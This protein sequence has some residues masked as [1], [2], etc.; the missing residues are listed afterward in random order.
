MGGQAM[1][2]YALPGQSLA[3]EKLAQQEAELARLRAEGGQ[4]AIPTQNAVTQAAISRPVEL[5][6][7]IA[8]APVAPQAPQAPSLA[9]G[10]MAESAATEKLGQEEASIYE[11]TQKQIAKEEAEQA[12]KVNA[13]QQEAD[14]LRQ[15]IANT[16]IEP[17]GFWEKRSTGEKI[18]AGIG[19]FLSSLTPQGAQN[20]IKIIDDEI[21]RDISLQEK[22]LAN[23]KNTL[24]SLEQKLGSLDAAK[25]AIRLKAAQQAELELKKV[26]AT[27]KG[28][29]VRAKAEQGLALAQ[30]NIAEKEAQLQ[31]EL[32]KIGASKAD[33][34]IPVE[35][36]KRLDSARDALK[37]VQGMRA[38]LAKGDNTFSLFGD[39]DFTVN[40]R[41]FAENIGRMQSGGAISKDEEER[42]MAMTPK[43]TD[44]AA[45]Q[46]KKLDM[47]QTMMEERI[48]GLGKD[49]G[50][51]VSGMKGIS[52]RK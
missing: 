8:P 25:A 38:A 20:A 16:K 33:K 51:Q 45:M 7:E 43:F 6:Q 2:P 36:Q 37:A 28:P 49:P 23:K 18:V 41:I 24:S 10:L 9:R 32:M 15:E 39:N 46:R 50:E 31:L 12:A 30:Q 21:E 48:R 3:D 4:V 52:F 27:A 40:Q 13:V 1:I 42:F 26:A 5:Q 22:N 34:K 19:L 11:K 44:S 35:E 14:K 29:L 17:K 47:L